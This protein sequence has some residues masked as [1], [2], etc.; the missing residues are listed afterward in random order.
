M[1]MSIVT[2]DMVA[3]Y[4]RSY[5]ENALE[6]VITA[7]E[8]HTLCNLLGEDFYRAL[9]NS[10]SS[11]TDTSF[12]ISPQQHLYTIGKL[13]ILE[14][15]QRSIDI[16]EFDLVSVSLQFHQSRKTPLMVFAKLKVPGSSENRPMISLGDIIRLRPAAESVPALL[17]MG[18]FGTLEFQGIVVSYQLSSEE[19]ISGNLIHFIRNN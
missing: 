18:L 3:M 6:R 12:R 13:I 2:P 16:T 4:L 1:L 9:G 15:L 7:F 17:A 11:T 5:R 19:V 8:L 14:E 10:P